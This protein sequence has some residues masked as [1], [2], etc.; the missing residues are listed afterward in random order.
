MT[1]VKLGISAGFA[2]NRYPESEVWL[3]IVRKELGLRYVQYVADLVEPTL[4]EHIQMEELKTIK[5]LSSEY[6]V[7]IDTAFTYTRRPYLMHYHEKMREE[8]FKWLKT[9]LHQSSVLGIRGAG[10]HFG[11][12]SVKDYNNPERKKSIVEEA[13]RSWR[14]LS[15]CGKSEGL[16]FLMFEPMSIPREMAETIDKTKE[17]WERVNK[18]S[19]LPIMLCL[20]VGHGSVNSGETRD[21]D[22]YIWLKQ[23]AHISPVIHICQTDSVKNVRHWPFTDQYNRLG[24]IDPPRVLEAIEASGA[25]DVVL[26]LEISHPERHPADEKV[27]DDLKCSVEYWR[28]YVQE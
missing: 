13:V 19:A 16:G 4:P 10:S 17:L 27:L 23:L 3:K 26:V 8:A 11:I 1:R 24:I 18:K 20:D 5:K 6:Q 21:S 28:T 9:F 15:E 25:E 12:M 22:P 14:R 7:K 2:V